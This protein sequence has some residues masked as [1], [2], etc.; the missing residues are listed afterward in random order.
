VHGIFVFVQTMRHQWMF[1]D[2]GRAPPAPPATRDGAPASDH[3]RA[4]GWR[5]LAGR[6]GLLL[7]SLAVVVGLAKM[8]APSIEQAVEWAGA[9]PSFVGVVIALV[10]LLPESIAAFRAAARNEMQTS[11][12]LALGSGLASIGLT[13]PSVA[14]A[15]IWLEGPI[16]LGL[17]SKEIV[18]LALT[19]AISI[20][21]F[22]SGRATVLQATHHMALFAAFVFLAAVP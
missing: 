21:T 16:V 10:V 6:V 7:L 4:N 1:V 11:I 18:L 5:A 15:S 2:P 9:P 13:I 14:V 3:D 17:D 19:T 12:N 20:L 8:L 22:G